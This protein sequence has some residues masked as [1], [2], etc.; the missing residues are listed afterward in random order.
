M[1][2]IQTGWRTACRRACGLEAVADFSPVTEKAGDL[3]TNEQVDRLLDRCYMA[4]EASRGSRVLDLACGTGASLGAVDDVATFLVAGD[5]T[6]PLLVQARAHYIERIPFAQ[7][8]A[9]ALPFPDASFDLVTMFEAIYYLPDHRRFLAEVRRV[10]APGGRLLVSTVNAEWDEAVPS[11]HSTT[12]LTLSDLR[13]TLGE[14]GFGGFQVTGAFSTE[15]AKGLRGTAAR[16]VRKLGKRANISPR[17][18]RGREFLKRLM[19]GPLRPLPAEVELG[20]YAPSSHERLDALET[21]T[22]RKILYVSAER[23]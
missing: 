4:V 15:G 18:L 1:A 21:C 8:D 20:D 5:I 10:L 23:S 19:Y 13:R 3:A 16:F 2:S 6:L 12:Y 7:L 17:T 9:M 14:S 22:S 11:A